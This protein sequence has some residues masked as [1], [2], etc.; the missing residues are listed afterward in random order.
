MIR[1]AQIA[2][3][4]ASLAAV[5]IAAAAIPQPGKPAPSFSV[6]SPDGKTVV[7]ERLRGRP[8]YL[9]FFAWWCGPCNDEAPAIAKLRAKYAKQGL[10]IVGIDELDPPG[11]A[12]A[13]QKKYSNPYS[14]VGVDESGALGK[15][16]GTV[17]L[18]LHV[19]IDRRGVVTSW[20]PGE[21]DSAQIESHIKEAMR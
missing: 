20:N 2:A 15:V 12:A 16:Y 8:V 3:L 19:F 10:T 11:Q 4:A 5:P 9:N 21:L 17:G 14:L 13:F 6:P 1:L 18:P 7:F